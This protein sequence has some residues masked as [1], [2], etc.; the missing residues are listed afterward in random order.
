MQKKIIR[1]ISDSD[2]LAGS[3]HLLITRDEHLYNA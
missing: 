3:V 1:I 2:Y